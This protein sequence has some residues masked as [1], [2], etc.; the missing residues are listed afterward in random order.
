MVKNIPLSALTH[1]RTKHGLCFF[2]L[3]LVVLFTTSAFANDAIGEIKTIKGSAT[4]SRQG[5]SKPLKATQGMPLFLHDQ[6]KSG[7]GARLRLL[8]KD[9]SYMTMGE[10]ANL[11]LDQFEFD[12]KKQE[13]NAEF[14][15]VVGKFKVFAK[16]LMK[17][18]KRDF[19]VKTPTA[20]IGVRGTVY[21]VWVVDGNITQVVCFQGMLEVANQ[22]DPSQYVNLTNGFSTDVIKNL[23]PSVPVLLTEEQMLEL[24]KSLGE[25]TITETTVQETTGES[26]TTEATTT[27]STT[28]ASTTTIPETTTTTLVGSNALSDS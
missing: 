2:I 20:V 7:P 10:K 24:Q 18:K 15:V 1:K 3:M 5:I 23:G 6:L 22:F 16:D 14:R 9:G 19:Q 26:T 21:M 4:V 25:T 27:V 28:A 17:F 12:A 11:H 13:R 8:F